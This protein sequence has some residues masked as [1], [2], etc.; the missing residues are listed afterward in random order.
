LV[1]AMA[2]SLGAPFWFDMLNKVINLRS[3]GKPPDPQP[4][5]P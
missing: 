1:T 2:L 4:T 5:K 3:S